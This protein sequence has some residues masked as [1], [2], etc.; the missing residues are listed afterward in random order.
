M[1]EV[2]GTQQHVN[3]K[4]ML[5]QHEKNQKVPAAPKDSVMLLKNLVTRNVDTQ[6]VVDTAVDVTCFTFFGKSSEEIAQGT[7]ETPIWYENIKNTR[8]SSGN[9]YMGSTLQ[10]V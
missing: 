6:A 8:L 1:F 4:Q 9:Q 3:T 7:M 5:Q 10:L 2:S